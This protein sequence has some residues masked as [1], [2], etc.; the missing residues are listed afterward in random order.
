[1][2]G[3]LQIG[4]QTGDLITLV[5]A[6][7]ALHTEGVTDEV[8]VA[9][10]VIAR[11]VVVQAGGDGQQA[12][13]QVERL[14]P[15]VADT[16]EAALEVDHSAGVALW[17]LKV[18]ANRLV[19]NHPPCPA[20]Q[21]AL[22][23]ASGKAAFVVE[24]ELT[25]INGLARIELQSAR[26]GS[27]PVGFY[28]FPLQPLRVLG[29]VLIQF[30]EAQAE[31]AEV[32]R[33]QGQLGKGLVED[34]AAVVAVT[35]CLEMRAVDDETGSVVAAFGRDAGT[36]GAVSGLGG[37]ERDLGGT[38]AIAREQLDDT[39][40]VAAVDAGEWP[41]QDLDALQG[42]EVEGRRLAWPSGLDSG[43][44]SASSLMPRIPKAERAPK[45]REDICRSCA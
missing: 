1:M 4:R 24:T 3:C 14:N 33:V 32:I 31:L 41:T 19:L 16:V 21:R 37:V 8:L 7:I 34:G 36:A 10:T 30:A 39:T 25:M 43:T 29:V 27:T 5:A 28:I 38:F 18:W 20:V 11:I 42:V 2:P 44:P 17:C 22:P 23:D 45:P 35:V 40:G 6:Q 13:T 26:R 9:L 15:A 12:A